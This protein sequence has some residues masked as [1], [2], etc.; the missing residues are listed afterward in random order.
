MY[1]EISIKGQRTD[2]HVVVSIHYYVS[3]KKKNWLKFKKHANVLS[4]S[5]YIVLKMFS[6]KVICGL[7]ILCPEAFHYI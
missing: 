5:E 6:S 4:V 3:T 1:V 2:Y 7:G